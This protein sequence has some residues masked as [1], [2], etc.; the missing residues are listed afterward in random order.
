MVCQEAA[1]I[2]TIKHT[3]KAPF[4]SRQG[5]QVEDLDCQD[6]PRLGWYPLLIIALDGATEVVDLQ[7]AMRMGI[8]ACRMKI[9]R[10]GREAL[11]S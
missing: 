1:A 7:H 4:V 11:A 10:Q 5:A 3:T 8:S 9:A 2:V 6:V